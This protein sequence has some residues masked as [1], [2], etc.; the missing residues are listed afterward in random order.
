MVVNMDGYGE[1]VV[2]KK[3]YEEYLLIRKFF[4][5][6]KEEKKPVLP[7]WVKGLI[8]RLFKI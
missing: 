6:P 3:T 2:D 1:Q 7:E 5:P 8:A 4:F